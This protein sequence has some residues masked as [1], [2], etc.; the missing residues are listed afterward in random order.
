MTLPLHI[1]RKSFSETS[2]FFNYARLLALFLLQSSNS[3]IDIGI[4]ASPSRLGLS[5]TS[6]DNT[7][8]RPLLTNKIKPLLTS[9]I[10]LA[11]T[12]KTSKT[13]PLVNADP[14]RLIIHRKGKASSPILT[15][16]IRLLMNADPRRCRL[17]SQQKGKAS[18]PILTS[19][20]RPLMNADPCRRLSIP[21]HN[22]SLTENQTKSRPDSLPSRT[23]MNSPIWLDLILCFFGTFSDSCW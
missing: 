19:K 14:R 16:K 18:S 23:M 1:W 9:K 12:S 3:F 21:Q 7:S 10:K 6:T 8:L 17:I 11:L 4:L 20:I 22:G 2:T 15:N 13:K 5:P